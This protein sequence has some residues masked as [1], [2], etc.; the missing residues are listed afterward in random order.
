[1]PILILRGQHSSAW[2][3]EDFIQ[4][5]QNFIQYPNLCFQEV[6]NAGHGLPFEQRLALIALI[7]K[8]VR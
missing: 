2:S 8:W 7:E 5:Q 4:E 6:Q 1:M 3:H